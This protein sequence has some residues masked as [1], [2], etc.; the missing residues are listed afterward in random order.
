M[1]EIANA[2]CRKKVRGAFNVFPNVGFTLELHISKL[3]QERDK[4]EGS[5]AAKT[6]YFS[7]LIWQKIT[8]AMKLILSQQSLS[9]IGKRCS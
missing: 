4:Q 6:G 9:K 5:I 8:S 1:S 3:T 7:E 2:V